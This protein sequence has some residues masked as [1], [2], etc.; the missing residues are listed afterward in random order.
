[1][2]KKILLAIDGSPSSEKALDEAAKMAREGTQLL[3]V[4]VACDPVMTLPSPYGARYD[5]GIVE[6]AAVEQANAVLDAAQ[7]KLR[8]LGVNAEMLLIDLTETNSQNI[9][10]TL[11]AEADEWGAELIIMGTHGRHGISRLILGSVAEQMA[12]LSSQ[13]VLLV[14]HTNNLLPGRLA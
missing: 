2:Y 5:I 1:M 11:I 13:P 10:A 14:R 6:H 7:K 8:E 9:P 12:R 3:V 4:V